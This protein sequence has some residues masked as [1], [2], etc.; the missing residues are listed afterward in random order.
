MKPI[1]YIRTDLPQKFGIPRNSFLA[2]HLQGR[3]IFE[4]EYAL[5][6]AV[7]G[8]DSFTH[9]WLIWQFENG[10]TGGTAD[11][12]AQDSA[13]PR[14]QD[15]NDKWSPTVRPPRLGGV[16]RVGVFAT[17]SPFRPNPLGLS[18][19]KLERVKITDEGPVLHV[20]GANLRDGTPILDIKPYIP[21]ADCHTDAQGG[22]IDGAPW[23]ELEV[24]F[25]ER[26]HESIDSG[27]LPGLLEVLKQD[28]RR[29]GSKH[30]PE[31]IY[32]LAYSS[33]DV[34]F[35]VDGNALHVI[36]IN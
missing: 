18:C 2:P 33:L 21:F 32:H 29:A 17:R 31:R 25:P 11:D 28:P 15:A 8:I 7:T 12:I 36:G 22:W 19:V 13:T 26:L 5:E 10:V 6:S 1:A 9:L 23:H 14:K 27:K 24:D 35:T 34:A 30:E 16:E 20:L 4:P 3:I